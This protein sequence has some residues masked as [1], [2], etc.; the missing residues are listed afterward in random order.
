MMGTAA[1]LGATMPVADG[2]GSSWAAEDDSKVPSSTYL[3]P[4]IFCRSAA[5]MA[6]DKSPASTENGGT[7]A[8]ELEAGVPAMVWPAGC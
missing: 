5:D 3:C 8:E 7:S 1:A 6:R 4:V 2:T